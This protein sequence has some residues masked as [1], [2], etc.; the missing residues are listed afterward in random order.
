M[1][2]AGQQAPAPHHVGQGEERESN[3]QHR[4]HEPGG[5]FHTV[6]KR[7]RDERYRDHR[8]CQLERD[9]DNFGVTI[10][11]RG[12]CSVVGRKN[13]SQPEVGERVGEDAADVAAGIR[14]RVSPQ[15]I[16]NSDCPESPE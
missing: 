3:P 14:H 1:I 6:G 15:D 10:A 4:K 7:T 13:S 5:E 2:G 16:N 11:T 12:E 8:E 9:V